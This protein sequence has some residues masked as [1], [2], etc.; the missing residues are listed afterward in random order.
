MK[1]VERVVLVALQ[2]SY[3]RAHARH[4]GSRLVQVRAYQGGRQG[5]LFVD[6]E[7]ATPK[8]PAAV[9]EKAKA[10]EKVPKPKVSPRE[11][12]FK[13]YQAAVDGIRTQRAIEREQY[14]DNRSAPRTIKRRGSVASRFPELKEGPPPLRS[15]KRRGRA[16][17]PR[18][19][20]INAPH[21]SSGGCSIRSRNRRRKRLRLLNTPPRGMT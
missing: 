12:A 8:A 5:N 2:K 14:H 11:R 3:V 16:T 9:P 13:K 15:L 18:G 21:S 19:I 4:S 7:A 1:S 10:P 17:P 6:A 20:L